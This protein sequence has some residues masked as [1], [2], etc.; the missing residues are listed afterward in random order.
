MEQLSFRSRE[1]RTSEKYARLSATV[2]MRLKQYNNEVEQLRIKL[3]EAA[4]SRLM[5]PFHL[6]SK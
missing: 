5:Y 2:R 3:Q 6:I 1:T 4:K